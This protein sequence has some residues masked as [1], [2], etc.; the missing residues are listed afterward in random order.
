MKKNESK[1]AEQRNE[2]SCRRN[3]RM[4]FSF[5][6]FSFEERKTKNGFKQIQFWKEEDEEKGRPRAGLL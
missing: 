1:L 2:N 5:L 3:G 6:K 4:G